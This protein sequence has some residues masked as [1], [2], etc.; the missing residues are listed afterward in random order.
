[1]VAGMGQK[2][3]RLTNLPL[4]VSHGNSCAAMS[5]FGN[6]QEI[7]VETW[8][9]HYRYKVSNGVK[10]VIMTMSKHIPSYVVIDGH[11]ALTSYDGQPH[12]CYGCGQIDHM[13]HACP[14]RRMSKAMPTVIE[15]PTWADIMAEK[16]PPLRTPKF[17]IKTTWTL[18]PTN[19]LPRQCCP[20]LR[21]IP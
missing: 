20:S 12:I 9:K 2:R 14:K 13:Y 11:R 19:N 17:Q 1:M 4:E 6:V 7:Q 15:K 8:A 3:V 18:A 10:I 21:K 5:Q 16:V